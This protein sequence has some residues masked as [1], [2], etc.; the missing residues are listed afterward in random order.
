[1][2]LEF[3][4]NVPL[5]RQ[6]DDLYFSR[7]GGWAE[8]DYVFVQGNNLPA[9]FAEA[10]HFTIAELGFGT[11]LSF[12][13]AL[14]AWQKHAPEAARLDF[15]SIE[16][17]PL[18]KADMQAAL[19]A[20]SMPAGL[21]EAL[22]GQWSE[23][24]TQE[25]LVLRFGSVTLHLL[26]GDVAQKLDELPEVVD[27]WFLDGFSPVKNGAMWGDAVWQAMKKKS[28]SA[29]ATAATY[30]CALVVREGLAFAGFGWEKVKGYGYKDGMIVA[31]K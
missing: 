24:M 30:S 12:L 5:S 3:L 27:A 9:R 10:K 14:A 7:H 16:G 1:M 21:A 20:Q 29:A 22:L 19:A 25:N 18:N 8:K 15:Y 11:G 4:N 6:F 26:V 17:Y 2:A 31:K 13:T 28:S 23:E